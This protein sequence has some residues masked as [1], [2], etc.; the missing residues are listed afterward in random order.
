MI[1]V[2][3]DFTTA[4]GKF[5]SDVKKKKVKKKKKENKSN[6]LSEKQFD[7]TGQTHF[8]ESILKNNRFI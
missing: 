3:Y 7:I 2:I 8:R 1:K 4:W 6:K 5:V